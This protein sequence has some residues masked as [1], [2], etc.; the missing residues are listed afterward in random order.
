MDI[1]LK[2]VAFTQ[3]NISIIQLILLQRFYLII[4]KNN[5]KRLQV[6]PKF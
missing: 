4:Y 2:N 1:F 6:N 5:L 3:F